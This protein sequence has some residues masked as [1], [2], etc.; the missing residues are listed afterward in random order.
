M[1]IQDLILNNFISNIKLADLSIEFLKEESKNA[2]FFDN[3]I[4]KELKEL[5]KE[6]YSIILQEG[7]GLQEIIIR[8]IVTQEL[9]KIMNY[10]NME[11]FLSFKIEY[12][13]PYQKE[14][15]NNKNTQLTKQIILVRNKDNLKE[16][17]KIK[18]TVLL[19]NL[20]DHQNG[21]FFYEKILFTNDNKTSC[22]TECSS[23]AS[24]NIKL[25]EQI[26][27]YL[28]ENSTNTIDKDFFDLLQISFDL[29]IDDKIKNFF[30]SEF[31][32]ETY[33]N[34]LRNIIKKLNQIEDKNECK[35]TNRF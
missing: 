26:A 33:E 8:N 18:K 22:R 16:V 4:V 9:L 7:T 17:R 5:D 12:N 35:T 10:S 34:E 3:L 27:N 13:N 23:K 14:D 6:K 1:K 20:E 19:Y 15:E 29:K 11:N 2:H 32:I 25:Y 31:G 30:I 28:S 21:E 24:L